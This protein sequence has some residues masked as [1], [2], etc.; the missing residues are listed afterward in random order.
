MFSMLILRFAFLEENVQGYRAL[1]KFSQNLYKKL[2]TL[3]W[4]L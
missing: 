3:L 4:S 1:W 2:L